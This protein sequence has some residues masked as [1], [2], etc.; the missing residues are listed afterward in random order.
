MAFCSNGVEKLL[1]D[2]R[3]FHSVDKVFSLTSRGIIGAEG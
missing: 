3:G 1:V 2:Y